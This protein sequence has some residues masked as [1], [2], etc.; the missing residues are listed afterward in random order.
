MTTPAPTVDDV[1]YAIRVYFRS[2]RCTVYKIAQLSGLGTTSLRD[3]FRDNWLPGT[4]TLRVL[5]SLIPDDFDPEAA[6]PFEVEEKPAPRPRQPK[7]DMDYGKRA[8]GGSRNA[9]G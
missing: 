9:A 6:P 2:Q 7:E 4:M 8:E 5:R 3:M 1:I